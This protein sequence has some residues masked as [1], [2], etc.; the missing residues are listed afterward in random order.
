MKYFFLFI[1]L[2][3]IFAAIMALIFLDRSVWP[4]YLRRAVIAAVINFG[5]YYSLDWAERSGKK[6]EKMNAQVKPKG[7]A[8]GGK[9]WLP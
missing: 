6:R 7:P 3:A 5:F 2:L 9:M 4:Q 8:K 1:A